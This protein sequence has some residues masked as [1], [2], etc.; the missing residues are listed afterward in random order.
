[1]PN[2]ITQFFIQCCLTTD[3]FNTSA[4]WVIFICMITGTL[5]FNGIER[6]NSRSQFINTSYQWNNFQ[7]P[8]DIELLQIHTPTEKYVPFLWQE[9][10]PDF[11]FAI[12]LWLL[13]MLMGTW[14]KKKSE[15]N[16]WSQKFSNSKRS[17]WK[18][19]FWIVTA[20]LIFDTIENIFLT[21]NF[22]NLTVFLSKIKF[23]FYA[24]GLAFNIVPLSFLIKRIFYRLVRYWP[25]LIL[26]FFVNVVGNL[27]QGQDMYINLNSEFLPPAFFLLMVFVMA[28]FV[29]RTVLFFSMEDKSKIVFWLP[30]VAA[31]KVRED[32]LVL[33]KYLP[34][35][36]IL[37]PGVHISQILKLYFPK[38]E[39]AF[40]GGAEFF[41]FGICLYYFLI[42]F[43]IIKSFALRSKLNKKAVF[44]I[45]TAFIVLC[46][47]FLSI[48]NY[49]AVMGL[50]LLRFNFWL[51]L[52]YLAFL[53]DYVENTKIEVKFN[54]YFFIHFINLLAL[55]MIAGIMIAVV[56]I[57]TKK[58]VVLDLN[59]LT[60]VFAYLIGIYFL[61]CMAYFLSKQYKFPILFLL[62]IGFILIFN[63]GSGKRYQV[64]S[65]APLKLDQRISLNEYID[66]WLWKKYLNTPEDSN[67]YCINGYGGGIRAAAYISF[68]VKNL[69]MS[70]KKQ[71]KQDFFNS[72][73]S[74]STVSG[75][76]PGAMLSICGHKKG[77][78]DS[79]LVNY[80]SKDYLSPNLIGLLASDYI[81]FDSSSKLKSRDELQHLIWAN[82]FDTVINSNYYTYFSSNNL[83]LHFINTA[84]SHTKIAAI[85]CPVK[86]E[87]TDFPGLLFLDST[88]NNKNISYAQMAFYSARF[89]IISPPA[90]ASNEFRF[91][92]GGAIDNSGAY[93]TLCL[94]KA[95]E[96]R[97]GR[98]LNNPNLDVKYKHYLRGLKLKVLTVRNT[99][100]KPIE[101]KEISN[102][103]TIV[104]YVSVGIDGNS[105]R[106]E[107]Q[108][109]RHL[110]SKGNY[111]AVEVDT[112][113]V[114]LPNVTQRF[115]GLRKGVESIPA[116]PILPLGW[117][118]GQSALLRL[119]ESAKREVRRLEGEGIWK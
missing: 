27:D 57:N 72:V 7:I 87:Q 54:G 38:Y 53:I 63:L 47:L 3:K 15:S 105:L 49:G 19:F 96:K 118:I 48:F 83:P 78:S 17:K 64:L 88:L 1:M 90:I 106:S 89:P 42:E 45:F 79:M 108:L 18:Y 85:S 26:L 33:V 97:I 60:T 114:L 14:L 110:E 117:Q 94:I 29:W 107:V 31:E 56:F 70:Y 73:F 20:A 37:I 8:S 59:I 71:F 119:Q 35:V 100:R 74:F 24:L 32:R 61:F 101:I 5:N 116:L 111:Y 58:P 22:P 103:Q 80:Y 41:L 109:M 6:H 50:S 30:N 13:A 9:I 23:L 39:I 69:E 93:T 84:E 95:I 81:K 98:L 28:L 92:D 67:V 51:L 77:I 68:I 115:L 21:L 66:K 46:S 34:A 16:E 91:M 102:I 36:L 10:F 55:I 86:M 75:S 104:N 52:L 2:F 113:K 40:I 76:S 43:N 82:N 65:D 99:E 4:K 44:F 62:L 12:S 11:L 112:N 25:V